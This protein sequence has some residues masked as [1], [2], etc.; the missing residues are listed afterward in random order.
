MIARL[1]RGDFQTWA[2]TDPCCEM[3][4]ATRGKGAGI[5]EVWGIPGRLRI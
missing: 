3:D 5:V 1:E 4:A 2:F